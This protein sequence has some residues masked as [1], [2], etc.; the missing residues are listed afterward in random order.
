MLKKLACLL[1]LIASPLF[2]QMTPQAIPL[3][4][5]ACKLDG[6]VGC[7]AGGGGG[8]GTVTSVGNGT[9][10]SL[11]SASWA[12]A[13]TTPRLSLNLVASAANCLV[14][15]PTS[16]GAAVPTCRAM[17]AAD[18]PTTL[19]LSY[20]TLALTP[21][22]DTMALAARRNS[23]GQTSNIVEF[24]TEVNGLLSAVD[25]DGV[26]VGNVTGNVTGTATPLAHASSHQNGGSDEVATATASANAIPKAGSGGTLAA[27]WLPALTGDVTSTAGSAATS[28][29]VASRTRTTPLFNAS[30]IPDATGDVWFEPYS[31]LATNDLY[32]H[33]VARYGANN[34]AA[35][36]VKSCVY[37]LAHIPEV[38]ST[39]A[40]VTVE[41]YWTSTLTSGDV[42]F[43]FDYRSIGGDNA[44]SLDQTT[45]QES[46]T[47][48][49]T[50]PGAAN[51]RMLA[52]MT[53]TASNLLAA[54]TLECAICRDGAD[55]ADT[56]AGSVL[57]H[58]VI[59]KVVN[60]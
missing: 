18:V 30:M 27:G 20:A 43:D 10:G 19:N 17:V 13:T 26:F 50:A 31:I 42:V 56:L 58:E 46:L 32:R 51:R 47:V 4:S 45:H 57:V 44:E 8:S 41:I 6:T 9:I 24:Q 49:D 12:T 35:P 1:A 55:A 39:S 53:L 52:T 40:T 38:Y 11:F 25:K 16:G 14:A 7:G 15:G 21:P 37:S 3:T 5:G 29:A 60:P 34:A 54:D 22:S 28:L 48:T 59:L 36:T 2:A 33:L 23:A